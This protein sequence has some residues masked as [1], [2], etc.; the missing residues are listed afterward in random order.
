MPETL[1]TGKPRFTSFAD[2]LDY[3][4]GTDHRYELIDGELVVLPPES[5]PNDFIANY[6]MVVLANS[7]CVPLRLIKVH[8]CEL[9]VPVLSPKDPQ[10]RYPDLVVLAP[11]HLNLTQRRLTITLDMPTPQLVVEVMS[12][13][14]SNRDR[15][16]H[17]K[18]AQYAARGI[19]E[20]WLID[21][22]A[23]SMTVFALGEG[24]YDLVGVFAGSDRILSP[25]LSTFEL[26]VE[27]ALP[28]DLGD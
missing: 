1:T 14:K 4:D 21:P 16:T 11:V 9:E 19:P 10:N 12:P 13:G 23:R 24:R 26:T 6:L 8:T 25:T 22:Q 27:Q 15:D 5:E 3:D 18:P 7:G 20:Y 28:S 17:R 2:Y